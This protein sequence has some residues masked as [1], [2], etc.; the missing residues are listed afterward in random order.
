MPGVVNASFYVCNA[1]FEL[2]GCNL[3]QKRVPKL[4]LKTG[5]DVFKF[6]TIVLRTKTNKDSLKGEKERPRPH[7]LRQG[8]PILHLQLGVDALVPPRQ[9][10]CQFFRQRDLF[11]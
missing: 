9:H 1:P 5:T 3:L 11:H 7:K 2:I 8:N 10:P 4:S 6:G